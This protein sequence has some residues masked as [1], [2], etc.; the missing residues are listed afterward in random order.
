MGHTLAALAAHVG[1]RVVGGEGVV[2]THV[3]D[4]ARA[5]AGSLVFLLDERH[6]GQVLR[7]AASAVVVGAERADVARP[8][9][10]VSNARLAMARL[11]PLFALPPP[12]PGRH[13]TAVVDPSAFVADDAHL[14]PFVVVGAGCHVGPG[15]VLHPHVVLGRH[16]TVGAGCTL[17]PHVVLY[18][19]V[20]VGAG[21]VLHAGTVLGS[22]GYGYV[23]DAQGHH[24]K[25]PQLGGVELGDDVELGALV[26]VDR[27]TLDATRIGRGTKI[28]NLVH[29]GHNDQIGEDVLIVSQTGLSGSVRV[30]D[31]ATLAGQVGVAGHLTIGAG[32]LVLARAG[33]TKDVPAGARVSGFPAAPHGEERRRVAALRELPRLREAV[34]A[35]ARRLRTEDAAASPEA[36]PPA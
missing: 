2:I 7:S 29:V 1:G 28:D 8:Q 20:S 24:V 31:R 13:A 21:V 35:M 32:A 4:P 23:Q 26:A 3:A 27:G 30:G 33:V 12:P 5:S 18:D 15:S 11:L 17:H 22:D 10:V 36:P 34:R 9:L 6:L 14:G 16:V 19:G 25:V